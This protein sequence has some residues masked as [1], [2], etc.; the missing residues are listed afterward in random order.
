MRTTTL[1]LASVSALVAGLSTDADACGSYVPT[2]RVLQVATPFMR[3]EGQRPMTFVLTGEAPTGKPAWTRIAPGTYDYTE[4]ADAPDLARPMEVTLLGPSGTRLVSTARRSFIQHSFVTH[5]PSAALEIEVKRG[6]FT[7]ALAGRHTGATW[8]ELSNEK[9]GTAADVA[10]AKST[11][12][13]PTSLAV[14][15]HRVEGSDLETVAVFTKAGTVTLVRQG[16]SLIGS[17][18]G[19]AI[20]A[21]AERGERFIIV[22]NQDRDLRAEP[23]Y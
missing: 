14:Y 10:W 12:V 17:F 11:G 18:D 6:E 22:Q 20:G 8:L 15:V 2:P 16:K 19:Y 21:M 1:L 7:I 4:V 23:L 5:K 13:V 3:G 9:E